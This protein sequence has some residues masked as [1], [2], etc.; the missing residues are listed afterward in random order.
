[1]WPILVAVVIFGT[2]ISVCSTVVYF[3]YKNKG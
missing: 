2:L 1:M 3:A